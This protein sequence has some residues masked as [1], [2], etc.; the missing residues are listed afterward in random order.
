VLSFS[1][2]LLTEGCEA[3]RVSIIAF[4]EATEVCGSWAVHAGSSAANTIVKHQT[5]PIAS[6]PCEIDG[7]AAIFLPD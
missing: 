7:F 5:R 2:V 1:G 4:Q 6:P 3:L